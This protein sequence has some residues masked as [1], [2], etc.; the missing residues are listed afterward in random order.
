M[1]VCPICKST[2]QKSY[3]FCPW[4]GSSVFQEDPKIIPLPPEKYPDWC[5]SAIIKGSSTQKCIP[6][7]LEL[8]CLPMSAEEILHFLEVFHYAYSSPVSYESISCD[9]GTL[10][11][12]KE[13]YHFILDNLNDILAEDSF[14]AYDR[15]YM[16]KISEAQ[17]LTFLSEYASDLSPCPDNQI[18]HECWNY[19]K[20][21]KRVSFYRLAR[22]WE[23]YHFCM[24]ISE[25]LLENDD[26]YLLV[27]TRWSDRNEADLIRMIPE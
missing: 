15:F 22:F 6:N 18:T 10:V 4:C 9:Q 26:L 8:R 23:K 1:K 14:W 2:I 7:P 11:F 19:N 16:A 24:A 5:R 13:E 21:A 17:M 3:P 20:P 25:G 27:H 12:R